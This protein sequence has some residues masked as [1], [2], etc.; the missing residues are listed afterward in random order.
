MGAEFSIE[1]NTE[2][3]ITLWLLERWNK[4]EPN[5]STDISTFMWIVYRYAKIITH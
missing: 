5:S 2:K 1:I 4:L 3:R